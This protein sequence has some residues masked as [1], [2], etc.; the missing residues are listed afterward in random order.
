MCFGSKDVVVANVHN[1]TPCLF[2]EKSLLI[3][4]I[5]GSIDSPELC[6]YAEETIRR[7][8]FVRLENKEGKEKMVNG[9]KVTH[10]GW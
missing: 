10:T 3:V 9:K 8:G 6:V 7:Q 5:G 1:E 2:N 4:G